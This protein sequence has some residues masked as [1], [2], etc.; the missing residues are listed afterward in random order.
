MGKKDYVD[1]FDDCRHLKFKKK[2]EAD[3]KM[4]INTKN[5][6]FTVRYESC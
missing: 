6:S 2:G 3:D 4:Q 5:E 1:R